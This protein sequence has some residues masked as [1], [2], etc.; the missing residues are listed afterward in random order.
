LDAISNTSVANIGVSTKAGQL[1]I[2]ATSSD[3]VGNQYGFVLTPAPL[4]VT[5]TL[6]PYSVSTTSTSV[7]SW[8]TTG[9]PD[10]CTASGAWS[11]NPN[12]SGGTIT[13]GP[14]STAG[15]EQFTLTCKNS[16][17]GQT[18]QASTLLLSV[19]VAGS[20]GD[21]GNENGN[22]GGGSLGLGSICL[23]GGLAAWRR[24]RSSR[25]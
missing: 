24:T 1:Q 18:A 10:S 21:N 13:V 20:S 8:T 7:L 23:L 17:N 5:L 22:G 3:A 11:D 16:V 4:T 6:A 9:N 14:F 12:P 25:R 2:V 15:T 19:T